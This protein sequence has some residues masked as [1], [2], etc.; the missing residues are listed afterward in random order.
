MNEGILAAI[1]ALRVK[2]LSA[3]APMHESE[4]LGHLV[5]VLPDQHLWDGPRLLHVFALAMSEGVAFGVVK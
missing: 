5:E 1:R 4:R 3:V 2:L